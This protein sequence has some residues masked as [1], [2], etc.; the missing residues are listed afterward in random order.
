MRLFAVGFCFGTSE[1]SFRNL[2][3]LGVSGQVPL[4]VDLVYRMAYLLVRV[5]LYP[6]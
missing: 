4:L 2:F 6:N 5:E 1:A 3:G